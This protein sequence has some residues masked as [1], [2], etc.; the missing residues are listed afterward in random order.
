MCACLHARA[1]DLVSRS[2]AI[3]CSLL[4]DRPGRKPAGT[5]KAHLRSVLVSPARRYRLS[6]VS[7]ALLF[8]A[9][10][11]C[12]NRRAAPCRRKHT[13]NTPNRAHRSLPPPKEG[14]RVASGDTVDIVW[15]R[16]RNKP[17]AA[18]TRTLAPRTEALIRER[19]HL[20]ESTACD[21]LERGEEEEED[22]KCVPVRSHPLSNRRREPE[23]R[24]VAKSGGWR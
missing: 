6:C 11:R 10:P 2:I 22:A 3:R 1:H 20:P 14:G 13:L 21:H 7:T 8:R 18:G 17:F 4:T 24:V 5:K 15:L 19:D 9:L 16:Y 23:N 12:R